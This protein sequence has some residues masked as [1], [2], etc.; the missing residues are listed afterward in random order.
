MLTSLQATLDVLLTLLHRTQFLPED[1]TQ[2]ICPLMT[3]G[4]L[5]LVQALLDS[6]KVNIDDVDE[7]YYLLRKKLAEVSA[8]LIELSCS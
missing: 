2:I 1:I 7:Q 5:K 6:S 4:G 3:E 8:Y